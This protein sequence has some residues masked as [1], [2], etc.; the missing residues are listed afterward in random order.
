MRAQFTMTLATWVCIIGLC[1][2]FWFFVGY[3]IKEL[4]EYIF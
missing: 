2:V 4:I 3:G 1:M